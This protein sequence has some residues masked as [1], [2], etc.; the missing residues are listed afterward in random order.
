MTP[1]KFYAKTTTTPGTK[2]AETPAT[3][4]ANPTTP[5][6]NRIPKLVQTTLKATPSSPVTPKEKVT[7]AK[8][9]KIRQ[10]EVQAPQATPKQENIRENVQKTLF[11]QLTNRLKLDGTL[12]L[13]EEEVKEISNE[14][15]LQLHKCFGDT[16][17]KY[18]N[19]YRSLIFNIKDV[20]NQTLWKRIC[21]KSVNAYQL[22]S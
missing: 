18:R 20:K 16:G 19:K 5:T 4:P 15:E 6:L 17:Q 21:E 14:I 10:I 13:T 12:K 7:P 11:E 9:P 1:Q 8:T 3:K 2:K 22:V